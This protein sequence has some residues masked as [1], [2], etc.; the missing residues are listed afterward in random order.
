MDVSTLAKHFENGGEPSACGLSIVTGSRGQ[1]GSYL[2]DLIGHDKSIGCIN[3][4][5]ISKGHAIANEFSIDLGDKDSVFELLRNTRPESIFHLA[6]RHG[7][8]TKMTFEKE[9]LAQMQRLHVDA[10]RNFLQAIESLGLDTHLVVAGSSRIFCPT[11]KITRVSEDTPPNP[12]DFYGETKLAAWEL[13]K[14]ARDEFGTRA[15]F[16]VLFNH[17]S[18]R[19]P[20]G[21]LSQD[22]A[23][24]IHDYLSGAETEVRVRDA[25][26]MGDWSDA[27]DVVELMVS[28]SQSLHPEDL[29]VGSGTLRTVGS[30]VEGTLNLF[31][32]KDAPIF[33]Y[34]EPP[35]L[36]AKDSLVAYNSRS[37]ELGLWEPKSSI[38]MAVFDILRDRFAMNS[39]FAGHG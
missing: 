31:G 10:T 18:P 1:D 26:F 19:R 2:R 11:E 32:Q 9:D 12:Q 27:R 7:P 3:P 34:R 16:L 25:S 30:I 36:E 38:E 39:G 15:S 4:N 29:V 35:T 33:S 21:Y 14:R 17:E 8:S 28:H 20:K 6:A 5:S 22:I 13:V 37:I 24:A 23:Q